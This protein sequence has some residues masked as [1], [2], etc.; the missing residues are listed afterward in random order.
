MT[1][2]LV[3]SVRA[4]PIASYVV[5]AVGVTWTL[6]SPLVLSALG[7]IDVRVPSWFHV[8]GAAGPF[9]AA[10]AVERIVHGEAGTA[11][12]LRSLADWRL[13]WQWFLVAVGSPFV[14]F[15]VALVAV[16]VG[17]SVMAWPLATDATAV[18]WFAGS[19]LSA[20]AYGA[21]EEIGWRGFALARLQADRS[22]LRAAVL[23]AV[24]WGAW[25]APFFLYRFEF[26]AVQVV[27]F[28]LGLLA[29]SVW[30]ASLFNGTGGSVFAVASWHA[31]WNVV[32]LLALRL[33]DDV[34]AIMTTAVVVAA[35]LVVL[36][37][38]PATLA[39]GGRSAVTLR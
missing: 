2:R 20:L 23:L 32:N 11:R 37:W 15:G 5:L 36:V 39:P 7:V 6:V 25:H 27:G 13:P 10:L 28:L 14:L 38:K 34:V 1:R 21:G 3:D 19:L 29:G 8:F 26:G 18:T 35:V 12:L 9:L 33:S 24:V 22:A 4:H 16:A 31:A 30:L 17:G